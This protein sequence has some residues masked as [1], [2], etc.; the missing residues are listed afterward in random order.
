MATAEDIPRFALYGEA[1]PFPDV[2]HYE[3]IS[4]RAPVH[5]WRIAPH[6]HS[7]LAQLFMIEDG[8]AHAVTDGDAHHLTTSD[9][10]FV[11]T[12]CVHEFTFR[13]MTSGAVFSFPSAL[14]GA[15]GPSR[16]DI[17]TALARPFATRATGRL[18]AAAALLRDTAQGDGPFRV[19]Q[20]VAL[21][22]SVLAIVA[23][24]QAR[25][26]KADMTPGARKLVALNEMIAAR[27]SR[28]WQ[29]SDYASALSIST[30]HL[31]R[32]CR[33]ATG[34]GASAYIERRIMEEAC[35]NLAFTSLPISEIGYRLGYSDPSHFSKRFRAAQGK[36]PSDYRAGF[37]R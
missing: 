26:L 30:G 9:I 1:D 35:R 22:H 6:R 37:A 29:A 31:S 10:L 13:P 16:A 27:M 8:A 12:S 34:M 15:L 2:I 11:S 17:A 23:E 21:A 18:R 4:A 14:V 3:T 19:Q 33:A 25:T 36:T 20:L 28:G 24:S 5:D 7:H 32:L